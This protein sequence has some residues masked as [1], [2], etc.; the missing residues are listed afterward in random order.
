MQHIKKIDVD[1]FQIAMHLIDIMH[2]FNILQCVAKCRRCFYQHILKFLS[3]FLSI[4]V[5]MKFKKN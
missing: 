2:D 4:V 1:E 5:F 3:N